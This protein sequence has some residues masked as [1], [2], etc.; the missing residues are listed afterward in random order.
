M[1]IGTAKSEFKK[2]LEEKDAEMKAAVE[3]ME[4]MK[5][6]FNIKMTKL[7]VLELEMIRKLDG[8]DD[9]SQSKENDIGLNI[10]DFSEL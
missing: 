1:Q 5:G 7:K 2:Q 4:Q 6:D 3:K 10:N 9:T 8:D